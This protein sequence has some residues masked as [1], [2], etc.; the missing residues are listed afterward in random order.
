V[1]APS[2]LLDLLRGFHS[3]RG[4]VAIGALRVLLGVALFLG[5]PESRAPE[6]LR[7][8]GLVIVLLGFAA[9]L[10]GPEGFRRLL[11][12]WTSRG[13]GTVRAWSG[14]AAAVGLALVWATA[15]GLTRGG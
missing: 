2:R 4:V 3:T 10:F 11:G 7:P 9:P 13:E 15:P 1:V 5:A 6:V 12:W 8:L 14:V